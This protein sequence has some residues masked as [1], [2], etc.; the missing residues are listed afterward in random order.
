MSIFQAFPNRSFPTRGLLDGS[1]PQETSGGGGGNMNFIALPDRSVPYR[2]IP[3]R[4]LPMSGDAEPEPELPPEFGGGSGQG[5]MLKIL[6][7]A[8][9]RLRL[10]K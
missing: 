10:L 3:D 1:F 9:H 7:V 4:A 2:S 6:K 5:G 8:L